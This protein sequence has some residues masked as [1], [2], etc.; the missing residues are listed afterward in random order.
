MTDKKVFGC[1]MDSEFL[2]IDV[3]KSITQ[4]NYNYPYELFAYYAFEIYKLLKAKAIE[5]N[6]DISDEYRY[7]VV[8][9]FL[10][11]VADQHDDEIALFKAQ[12]RDGGVGYAWF[13][14][15]EISTAYEYKD[16]SNQ[17]IANTQNEVKTEK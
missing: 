9:A 10:S 15:W 8:N 11:F 4:Q 13:V 2:M 5:L 17:N 16:N 6:A 14:A 3:E 12:I 7:V 1:D